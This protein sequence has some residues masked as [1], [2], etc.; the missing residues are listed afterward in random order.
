M[1]E[2]KTVTATGGAAS[3]AARRFASDVQYY[4]SLE[5]RQLPSRYFYDALGSALFEAICELPWYRITRAEMRLLAAHA[6]AIA[7]DWPFSTVVELGPGSG[8]KLRTL[9]ESADLEDRPIAIHLIDVSRAA[10]GV[11]S[12]TLDG[13]DGARIVTHETTYEAGLGE[14]TASHGGEERVLALFLGSNIGNFDPPGAGAFLRSIR[15]SLRRGDRF[16][17][18]A[19]LVKS[20]RSLLLAYDDPLGVTAAFNRNLL[21]RLNRELEGDFDLAAFAHRAIWNAAN[22]RVEMHLVSQV[23]QTVR[24]PGADLVFT[25]DAGETIWTESSYKYEPDTI[26][27]ILARA[28]FGLTGQWIDE[29]DRFALTL[30]EAL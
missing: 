29:L 1:R 25:M 26:A 10:L 15:A 23:R 21:L 12:A 6:R 3:S 14:L 9:I 2:N 28:G 16:L 7:G 18:G 8:Q 19:D 27:A 22:S 5:P 17:I 4:L 30:V 24:V 13:L 20:E 11:A